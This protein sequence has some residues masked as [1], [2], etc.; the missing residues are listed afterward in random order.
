MLIV[1]NALLSIL[2]APELLTGLSRYIMF[3]LADI[4]T[5]TG[6]TGRIQK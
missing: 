4:P 3:V 2:P 1:V 5:T 6:Y